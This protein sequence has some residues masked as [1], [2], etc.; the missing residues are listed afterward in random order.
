MISSIK[1]QRKGNDKI[2]KFHYNDQMNNATSTMEIHHIVYSTDQKFASTEKDFAQS[3]HPSLEADALQDEELLRPPIHH[4]S[5]IHVL[6]LPPLAG[7]SHQFLQL[8]TNTG[9]RNLWIPERFPRNQCMDLAKQ[10]H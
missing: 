4:F 8:Q 1:K 5:K 10:R 3:S 6:V 7:L 9:K 2:E